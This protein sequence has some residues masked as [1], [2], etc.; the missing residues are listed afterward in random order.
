MTT[1]TDLAHFILP[2][3][4]AAPVNG[5][6]VGYASS[7]AE[8]ALSVALQRNLLEAYAMEAFGRPLDDFYEDFRGPGGWK[9]RPG[10]DALM[11]HARQGEIAVIVVENIDR[12]A[13]RLAPIAEFDA[14]CEE[15]VIKLH[16]CTGGPRDCKPAVRGDLADE[17]AS[18]AKALEA[19]VS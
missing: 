10:M 12:I 14:F 5:L 16:T 9:D 15:M 7:T 18:A 6:I 11:H 3:T 13:R 8:R 17:Q 19:S 4:N 2:A 1:R